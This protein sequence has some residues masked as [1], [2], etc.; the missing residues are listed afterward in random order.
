VSSE[1]AQ[2]LDGWA[3]ELLRIIGDVAIE[4]AGRLA[5]LSE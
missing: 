5:A 2:V 4:A 3:M 1:S